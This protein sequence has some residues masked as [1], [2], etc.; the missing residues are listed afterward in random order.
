LYRQKQSPPIPV[1]CGSIT[2]STAT[3]A[4]AASIALPPARSMSSA[5]RVAAGMD[6]AAMPLLA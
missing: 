1:D 2:H 4:M 3:A 5:A 6:V